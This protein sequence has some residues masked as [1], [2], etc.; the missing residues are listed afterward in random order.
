LG[1]LSELDDTN[2]IVMS[3]H[4]AAATTT[5][6]Y[7]NEWLAENGYLARTSGVEDYFQKVGLTRESALAMAKRLGIVDTLAETD[8]GMDSRDRPTER[9]CKV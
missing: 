5:E 4:G 2:L 8:P 9:R 1:K 3:D 6:F 7:I